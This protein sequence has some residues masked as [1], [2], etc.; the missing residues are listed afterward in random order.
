MKEFFSFKRVTGVVALMLAVVMLFSGC[1]SKDTASNNSNLGSEDNQTQITS[2]EENQSTVDGSKDSATNNGSKSSNKN[3]SKTNSTKKTTFASDPYSEISS[4]V[5]SKGVHVLMWRKYT[6]LEQKLVDD[7]QKKT[8]IKVRTTQTTESEYSTKLISLVAGGDSPDVVS[9]GSTNF[10]GL[11]TKSMQ[12]LK[13]DVYR[14]D[15][16]CWYKDYMNAFKVNGKYFTVAMKG[17]WAAE[18]T[19]YVTY[20]MPKVLKAAGVS[21][22]PWT[23]YKKGQWNWEKQREIAQ[24]VS[25]KSGYIGIS[26]QSQDLM[27]YSAGVDFVSYNGN[28]FKNELGNASANSLLTKA[29]QQTAALQKDGISSGWA[30]NN[31]QQGKVGLFTAIAYGMYNANTD[32]WFTNTPHTSADIKAVPVAGP[33]GG[34]AYTP[35]RPKAWGTAKKAKNPEGAAFFLRYFLDTKNCDMAGSFYNEQFREVFNKITATG[36]KKIVMRGKGIVDYVSSGTYEGKVVNV[37]ANTTSDQIASKLN[38]LKGQVTT[39]MNR[40]NKELKKVK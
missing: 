7:F 30:L 9:L 25:K 35:L 3:N 37:L 11:A 27:M 2:G 23:L 39:G 31:V 19:N 12:T 26:F 15:D 18:D 4:S 5:K 13:A 34:T 1:G 20:Y 17:A 21:E 40:A 16:S 29:W 8:G 36:A 6:T 33:K 14:L 28:Q 38:S 22:D 32:A 24:K 10:P